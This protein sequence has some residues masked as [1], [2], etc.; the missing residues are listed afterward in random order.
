MLLLKKVKVFK[1]P[2]TVRLSDLEWNFIN[3]IHERF[4]ISKS[5]I[6]RRCIWFTLLLHSKTISLAELI[7][8]KKVR[9][10]IESIEHEVKVKAKSDFQE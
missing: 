7:D 10:L 5:E 6:I 4:K 9:E 2:I 8:W 3:Y 1:K